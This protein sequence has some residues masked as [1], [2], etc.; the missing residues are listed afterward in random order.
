MPAPPSVAWLN[1]RVVPWNEAVLPIEDRAVQFAESLYEVLPVTAGRVRLL[2]RHVDRMRKAAE[3][4]ELAP[5]VPDAADW[6]ELGARLIEEEGLVEGLLYAQLTGGVGPRAFLPEPRPRPNFC[7]YVRPWRFPRR[8]E[9]ERGIAAATLPDTRW[10]SAWL[11][12]TMLLPAVLNKREAARRGADE[13]LL[14]SPDG[15]VR[16]G[17]SSN[18]FLVEAGRILTP[19]STAHVL[20]GITRPLVA[21]LAGQA[22]REVVEERLARERLYAADEVFITS[23]SRLVMPLTRIDGDTIGDGRAGPVALD[24]AARLRRRLDRPD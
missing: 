2:D 19:P 9:A 1:G 4:L 10:D 24:L 16:E 13:A 8:T 14:T 6:R 17:A 3:L 23:T 12:T 15:M 20:P 21:S 18:L 11:K 22:G 7:A 5:G